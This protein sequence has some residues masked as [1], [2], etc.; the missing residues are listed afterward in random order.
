MS[1]CVTCIHY[2]CDCDMY[3]CAKCNKFRYYEKVENEKYFY[4]CSTC[5]DKEC[6]DCPGAPAFNDD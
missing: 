4:D 1:K 6:F 3:P 5:E 2:S